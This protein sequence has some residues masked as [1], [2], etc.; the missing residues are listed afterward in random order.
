MI[1][2]IFPRSPEGFLFRARVLQP[3]AAFSLSIR[4]G[5]TVAIVGHTGAGKSTLGKLI[6]RFYEFQGG[7]IRIDGADIRSF[8]LT[9]Y[10]RQLGIVPQL[11]FL[12][13]G[14]VADNIRYARPGLSDDEVQQIARSIGGGDWLAALPQGVATDVGE[15]GTV[16]E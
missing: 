9:E 1:I 12:F 3:L 4:A 5:E 11:P 7:A 13:S 10:R 14:T 8:D 16:E 2:A 15:A 6:A